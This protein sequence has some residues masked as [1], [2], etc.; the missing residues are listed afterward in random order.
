MPQVTKDIAEL[1]AAAGVDSEAYQVFSPPTLPE[2]DGEQITTEET[3]TRA[4]APISQFQPPVSSPY[5]PHSRAGAETTPQWQQ[6]SQVF[7]ALRAGLVKAAKTE[8]VIV[9]SVAGG[10]GGSTVAATLARILSASERV[11]VMEA[12]EQQL[13]PYHF[14]VPQANPGGCTMALERPNVRGVA[15]IFGMPLT[16]G[17]ARF[18]WA[19]EKAAACDGAY[20]RV[21][22]DAGNA[23]GVEVLADSG[24]LVLLVA[25]PDTNAAVRLP[26]LVPV[27]AAR[28]ARVKL[29]LNKF[30]DKQR[31]HL[32]F[33]ARLQE[34]FAEFLVPAPIH[35]SPLVPEALAE[36]QTIIDFAP[37]SPVAE[38]FA[39]LA[40]WLE[41]RQD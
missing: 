8:R 34:H 28:G 41:R 19:A 21:I 24:S 38:D 5:S 23:S 9:A 6:L 12:T 40:A 37:A 18:E 25:V 2:T 1:C 33:F 11:A 17:A 13:L 26:A 4:A 36:G 10:A 35:W 15:H 27:L 3:C 14:G 20:S 39:R 29:L 30:D 32:M 7:G 31:L 22:V 16:A